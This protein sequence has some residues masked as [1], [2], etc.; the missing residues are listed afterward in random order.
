VSLRLGILGG[1]FDPIHLGHLIVAEIARRLLR[2]DEVVFV[3]ARVPPHKGSVATS[4]D[5]RFRMADLATTDN[6]GFRVSD[7]EIRREG[8]S[9]TID[10]LRAL[11]AEGPA[12]TE[13]FLLM[14]ADS[15]RDLASWK[16]HEVLLEES[17]VAVLGRPGVTES[18]LPPGLEDRVTFLD[19]PL[20]EISSTEIRRLV[21]RGESIRYLV[22]DPVE[23]FIRSEGLYLS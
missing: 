9:Y 1:T 6:P 22:T 4:P 2:L 3:P 12:G 16:D 14:G 18:D 19:T 23:S 5:R 20:V 17:T 11:R 15:A 8:P 13:H 10:T 7:V 21:R